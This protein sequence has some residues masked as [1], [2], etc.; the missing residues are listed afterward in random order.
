MAG[1]ACPRLAWSGEACGSHASFPLVSW[2]SRL[3]R[4][5][6]PLW[7]HNSRMRLRWP[8]HAPAMAHACPCMCPR[9][10]M[11][12]GT[13]GTGL[14]GAG[15]GGEKKSPPP[16]SGSGLPLLCGVGYLTPTGM[17]L[18][19]HLCAADDVE[20]ATH[21]L[22][23]VDG[24]ALLQQLAVDAVDVTAAVEHVGH[25]PDGVGTLLQGDY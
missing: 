14:S 13:R 4:V 7:C 12:L 21:G 2:D 5:D 6:V 18:D 3:A 24:A 23:V 16:W 10:G 9:R 8:M 15:S 25:T 11:R 20:A 17:S 22:D 19:R 1:A